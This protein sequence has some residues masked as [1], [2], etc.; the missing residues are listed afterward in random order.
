MPD[1]DGKIPGASPGGSRV[2]VSLLD[3]FELRLDDQ[4]VEVPVGA[5][6]LIALLGLVGPRTRAEAAARMWPD[7][8]DAQTQGCLRTALWRLQRRLGAEVVLSSNNRL[9]L[10]PDIAIDTELLV[11]R[12]LRIV[13]GRAA[14]LP[15]SEL[16]VGALATGELLPGW[17]DDWVVFERERLRELRLHALER[18]CAWFAV[19]K[20]YGMAMEAALAAVRE[21]PLR[22]SA[23]RAVIKV[24]L[25]Q[26]N[27][28]QARSH[29][30]D[31]RR[32]MLIE[33]QL[34]PTAELAA[35]VSTAWTQNR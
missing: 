29:Y 3:Q 20:R 28:V 8:S 24:H 30:G 12:A 9:R 23:R 16:T 7:P 15:A 1:S 31:F 6:R 32:L 19:Q 10:A 13:D 5:Q 21:D 4:P 2:A 34:E 18:L 35:L 11:Y 26:G 17:E 14:E 33:L 22:E 25:A 27:L